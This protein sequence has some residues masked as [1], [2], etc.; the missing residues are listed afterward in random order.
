[1]ANV[2]ADELLSQV[3]DL[4]D[5]IASVELDV[6]LQAHGDAAVGL[7]VDALCRADE[8]GRIF[9]LHALF[10][11]GPPTED[12]VARLAND[13]EL[14]PYALIWR[15]HTLDAE[16]E[17]L[18]VGDDAERLVRHL[19]GALSLWG[20][21]VM[22]AWLGPASGRIGARAAV[23]SMWRVRLADTE[24]VLATLGEFHADKQVA[25]AARK[26]LFKFRSSGGAPS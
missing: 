25:K 17:E 2:T 3:A 20:P 11:L 13:P 4:P 16:P 15:V 12:H 18:D 5:D 23:D 10:R 1:L 22:T 8:T 26:S 6:W 24:S 9:A 19:N 14:S 7:I 21:D